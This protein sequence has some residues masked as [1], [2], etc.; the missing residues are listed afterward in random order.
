M[1]LSNKIL[2]NSH[3]VV[4]QA[5]SSTANFRTPYRASI[6]L[7]RVNNKNTRKK[8]EV[9]SKLISHWRRSSVFIVNFEHI[10]HFV[11]VSLLLTLNM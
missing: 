6:Y 7:L 10:S 8:C 3:T 4:F 5:K 11:L 1:V 9:C 2:S